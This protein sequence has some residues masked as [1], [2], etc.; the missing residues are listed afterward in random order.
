MILQ[1]ENNDPEKMDSYYRGED[2]LLYCS[3]CHEPKEERYPDGL[4]LLGKFD[5]HPRRCACERAR[6]EKAEQEKEEQRHIQEVERLRR[7]CFADR[8]QCNMT[9]AESTVVSS[10]LETCRRYVEYWDTVRENNFGLLLWGNVGTGKSYLAACIANALIE[11][12][13]SVR[14]LNFGQILNAGFEEKARILGDLAKYGLLILDDFGME[15]S[16]EYGQEI[17]FQVIDNRYQSRKP[18]IITTNL[19]LNSLKSPR[20]L[21][22]ERIYGR[23]LEACIPIH[24]DGENLR[25]KARLQKV[26]DFKRLIMSGYAGGEHH[27]AS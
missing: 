17:I 23:I 21:E 6:Q 20:D 5:K 4:R 3:V 24:F 12:E 13:V 7:I 1:N 22:H 18:M 15:R 27:E 26:R 14:M 9:F 8:S 16:T 19:S 10:R 25:E 2:G 11:R